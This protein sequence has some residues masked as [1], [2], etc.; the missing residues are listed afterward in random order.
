MTGTKTIPVRGKRN[1]LTFLFAFLMLAVSMIAIGAIRDAMVHDSIHPPM[2][3]D[4]VLWTVIATASFVMFVRL[5]SS[6]IR[7]QK[8]RQ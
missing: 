3:A 1:G 6:V 5:L 2:W 7:K 8:S 4:A